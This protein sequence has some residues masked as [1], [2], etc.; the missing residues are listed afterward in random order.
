MLGSHVAARLYD[1]LGA[2]RVMVGGLVGVSIIT[3]LMALAGFGTT[4]WYMR[5]LMFLI[6][7]SMAHLMVPAQ[8]A[9]FAAV[10]PASTGRA[11]GFFNADRQLASAVGVA[12][13]TTVLAAAGA[14]HVVSG[15]VR[16]NL[17]A[18]HLA[19]LTAA[20]PA[21]LGALAAGMIHDVDA[22]ATFGIRAARRSSAPEDRAPLVES[23]VGADER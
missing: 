2:R 21:L 18:Y 3:A 10:T 8:A 9:A 15:A 13:V 14:Q 11:S 5:A 19:F 7:L 22:A 16:P 1:R 6:G 20:G 4:L 12:V 23:S 17:E